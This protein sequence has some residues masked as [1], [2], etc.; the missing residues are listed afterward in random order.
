MPQNDGQAKRTKA[1]RRDDGPN[2]YDVM[3]ELPCFAAAFRFDFVFLCFC[4]P[5]IFAVV[6]FTYL[7]HLIPL[8]LLLAFNTFLILAKAR[9][10]RIKEP[11]WI[12]YHFIYKQSILLC[13]HRADQ[14]TP[15]KTGSPPL[16]ISLLFLPLVCLVHS[17]LV[18]WHSLFENWYVQMAWYDDFCGL[19]AKFNLNSWQTDRRGPGKWAD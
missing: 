16:S 9:R 10:K 5:G 1:T 17:L 15:H 7:Y 8:Q 18:L 13:T 11:Q 14:V 4:F 6:V 19:R 2:R 12:W 3:P